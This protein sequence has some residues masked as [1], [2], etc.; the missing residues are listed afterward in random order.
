MVTTAVW[1]VLELW[2]DDNCID[3]SWTTNKTWN[4][5]NRIEMLWILLC[6]YGSQWP[7]L[8]YD[9]Q[10]LS[11]KVSDYISIVIYLLL[12]SFVYKYIYKL[13]LTLH[14][15][16]FVIIIVFMCVCMWN[17][18]H[19]MKVS[20][21]QLFLVPS[22]NWI[23]VF[24][25]FGSLLLKTCAWFIVYVEGNWLSYNG[26]C[27][28]N[29]NKSRFTYRAGHFTLSSFNLFPLPNTYIHTNP[30]KVRF[31]DKISSVIEPW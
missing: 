11:S 19:S 14:I 9:F 18:I 17:V 16:L 2:F 21:D 30:I 20:R 7:D 3:L 8:L 4:L 26:M 27:A 22:I 13:A 5:F 23:F 24:L 31:V 1:I 28:F 12:F 6:V 29:D 25:S 15:L 10:V